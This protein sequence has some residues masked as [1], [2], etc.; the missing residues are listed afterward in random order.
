MKTSY[1]SVWT[2]YCVVVTSGVSSTIKPHETNHH[3]SIEVNKLTI[4]VTVMM[5]QVMEV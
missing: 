3:L 5:S 2:L 4:I 1:S